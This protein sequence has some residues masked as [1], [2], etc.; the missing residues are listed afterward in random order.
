MFAWCSQK[1]GSSAAVFGSV[2]SPFCPP[3]TTCTGPCGDAS[4]SPNAGPW[5]AKPVRGPPKPVL[6]PWPDAVK[7]VCASATDVSVTASGNAAPAFTAGRRRLVNSGL[8]DPSGN[9]AARNAGGR[10][11]PGDPLL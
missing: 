9:V 1:I 4:S 3:T 7:S 6:P 5:C 11:L 2:I 10:A 8:L